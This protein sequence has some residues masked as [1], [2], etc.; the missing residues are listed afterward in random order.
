MSVKSMWSC[1]ARS[2]EEIGS[3]ELFTTNGEKFG[4]RGENIVD[5]RLLLPFLPEI[6]PDDP[7]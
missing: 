3:R 2:E 6:P 1:D 4:A 7:N 5:S